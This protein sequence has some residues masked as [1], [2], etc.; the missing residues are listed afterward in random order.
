MAFSSGPSDLSKSAGIPGL[1]RG[2]KAHPDEREDEELIHREVKASA[3]KRASGGRTGEHFIDKAIKHPGAL[4]RALHVPEGE[5][6]PHKKLAKAEHA[7]NPHIRREADFARE[8]EGFHK[9]HGDD[10]R[11]HKAR[12]GSIDPI[13]GMRPSSGGRQPRKDGGRAKSGKMDVNIIIA[14]GKGQDGMAPQGMGAARPLAPPPNPAMGMP[15]PG[16]GPPMPPPGMPPPGLNGPQAPPM[17]P[18]KRGGRTIEAGAGSGVGRL[19]KA[20]LY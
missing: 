11:I 1:K 8:L 15:P 7:K 14:T 3:L 10:G 12:G 9:R 13:T 2:G 16:A 6:I 20:G 5:D 19:E 18:R 17:M 4:H